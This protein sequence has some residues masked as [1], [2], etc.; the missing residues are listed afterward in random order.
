MG[1]T[2]R[3]QRAMLNYGDVVGCLITQQL[4][5]LLQKISKVLW[6]SL[7]VPQLTN[8]CANKRVR[9]NGDTGGHLEIAIVIGGSHRLDFINTYKFLQSDQVGTKFVQESL[10]IHP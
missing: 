1:W 8:E 10:A 6:D 2:Y 4:T 7:L 9:R 3:E 5:N